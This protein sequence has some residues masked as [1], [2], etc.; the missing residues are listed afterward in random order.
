[1][2]SSLTSYRSGAVERL[3]V[4][5][6]LQGKL[7]NA[8]TFVLKEL[9]AQHFRLFLIAPKPVY[10]RSL[11]SE[12][13]FRFPE[14]IVL[15][16]D[17]TMTKVVTWQ[18]DNAKFWQRPSAPAL[19]SSEPLDGIEQAIANVEAF[20]AVLDSVKL[21]HV[22]FCNGGILRQSGKPWRPSGPIRFHKMA[23]LTIWRNLTVS[24]RQP[25]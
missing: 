12:F 19:K 3:F 16:S 10:S 6:G 1:M 9:L 17:V 5:C 8:L 7:C 4:R 23:N 24:R 22:E 13:Q 21:H 2:C 14:V 15:C 20:G 11:H 25:G 18:Q